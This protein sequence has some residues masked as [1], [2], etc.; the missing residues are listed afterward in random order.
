M[1]SN[2][3]YPLGG[4]VMIEKEFGLFSTIFGNLGGNTRDFISIA[5]LHTYNK[6][7][8]S[9]SVHQIPNAYPE[10]LMGQLGMKEKPSE[11]TLYIT[12]ERIG[13]YFPVVLDR[14][15]Q[16]I[17]DN[18]LADNNQIIDFSSTYVEGKKIELASYGYSR[19]KRP[20]K[21]QINFGISTGINGIPTALTIQ[22]GNV[23]SEIGATPL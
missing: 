15:Q 2:K 17:K 10:E 19:D 9:V 18:G 20:D 3:T 23:Q 16:F 5:K 8:H 14:Y 4:I 1:K 7:T 11:R 6:L 22:K 13:R 12:L 21:L